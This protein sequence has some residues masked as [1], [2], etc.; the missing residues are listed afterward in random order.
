MQAYSRLPYLRT[1]LRD[2]KQDGLDAACGICR[3]GGRWQREIGGG[4]A[5]TRTCWYGV[6]CYATALTRA[7]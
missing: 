3:R 1:Y 4:R 7:R 6:N 2:G 5:V